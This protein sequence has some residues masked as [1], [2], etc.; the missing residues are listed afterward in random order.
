LRLRRS[1]LLLISLLALPAAAGAQDFGVL[2]SA[3]TIN[4]GNFKLTI[5]PMFVFGDGEDEAGIALKAGYGFTPR[6]DME[7]K[8]AFYEGVNFFGFDAEYWLLRGQDLDVSVSGGLHFGRSDQAFDTTG[9]DVTLLASGQLSPRLEL[10]AALD[11]AFESIDADFIDESFTTGHLVPGIEYA[12]SDEL[13]FVFEV[14]L[15]L[16]DNGSH[17]LS[18]GL[19]Y[20]LR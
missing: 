16:N 11:L 9:I 1:V 10:F 14:G 17:Y 6:F 15:S 13:D 20:Y 12:I 19:A 4:Q 3:E 8:A 5:N 7:A 2:E 18:G